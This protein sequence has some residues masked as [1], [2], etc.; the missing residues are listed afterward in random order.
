MKDVLKIVFV[1]VGNTCRSP[2]AEFVT[3]RKLK[4]KNIK[5]V[6]VLS[7]GISVGKGESINP[8][9]ERVLSENNIGTG[10]F[11]PKKINKSTAKNCDAFIAMTDDIKKILIQ[12]GYENVYSAKD[13]VG[14][15][16]EDPYGKGFDAYVECF[17]II[18]AFVAEIV[19]MI[20]KIITE[21]VVER[22]VL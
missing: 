10:K 20:E 19:K 11:R 21:K 9:A 15:E 16:I 14:Y 8:F 13:F 12:K 5:D 3:K 4:E 22:G 1:C 18:E 6:S 7:R 2:I 17:R